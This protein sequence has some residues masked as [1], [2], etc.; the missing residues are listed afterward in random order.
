MYRSLNGGPVINVVKY[1][2]K[3]VDITI[4]DEQS[5]YS[6]SQAEVVLKNFLA[7]NQS[8]SFSIKYKGIAS[9]DN[10]LFLIGELR[11]AHNNYRVSIFFKQK[12]KNFFLQEIKFE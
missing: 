10:S 11:T 3:V 2:D 6:R 4:N 5:T 1:F 8:K 9:S 7:K 12:D